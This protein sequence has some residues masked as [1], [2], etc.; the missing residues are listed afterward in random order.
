[1]S[2][3]CPIFITEYGACN[4]GTVLA[5]PACTAWYTFLDQNQIGS[6]CWAVEYLDQCLSIFTHSAS[7]TGPWAASVITGYG[8]FIQAY[9]LKGTDTPI[10]TEVLPYESKFQQRTFVPTW[11]DLLTGSDKKSAV[12]TLNGVRCPSGSK[13]PSGLHIV[14]TPGNSSVKVV[15]GVR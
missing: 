14:Q 10:S 5:E 12:F 7:N 3:G 15:N 1:M 4:T 8:T 9:I 11:S 13:L 2:K 6:T